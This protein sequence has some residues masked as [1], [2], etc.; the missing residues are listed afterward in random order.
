MFIQTLWRRSLVVV[1]A[2]LAAACSSTDSDVAVHSTSSVAQVTSECERNRRSCIYE[3][4][5]EAD[6]R[7]YAELE[8]R[9]LNQAQLKRM[10]RW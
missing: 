9:R 2:G 5:Y 6:E 10:R 1:C 3:G 7:N 8:A 4:R